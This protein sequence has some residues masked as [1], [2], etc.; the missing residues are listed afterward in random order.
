MSWTEGISRL[1]LVLKEHRP[2]LYP[3]EEWDDLLDIRIA[4][5]SKQDTNTDQLAYV[6]AV[7]SGLH[8]LNESLDKSHTLSQD[9][10]NT[11][12]SYWHGIMHRM[13]GDYSN[14]KY[15]FHQVGDHPVFI[16]LHQ[17][18]KEIYLQSN[19]ESISNDNLKG[20]LD[21]LTS[22]SSWDPYGFVDL[23]QQQVT[24]A[25]DGS[26]EQLLQQ[27]QWIE[28]KLLLQYSYDKSG[29]T[30]FEF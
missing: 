5:L 11:T 28:I 8:L 21:R 14:S 16:P 7:Q 30:A 26:A 19:A 1:W 25:R 10:H 22:S 23:V 17:Q 18:I 6:H 29:G 13:E 3:A 24:I 15:W 20:R 12:G 2:S 4:K 9:I 27:I